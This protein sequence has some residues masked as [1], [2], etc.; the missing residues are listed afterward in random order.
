MAHF[1][2]WPT[3]NG[4]FTEALVFMV[5]TSQLTGQWVA[6]FAAHHC[7]YWSDNVFQDPGEPLPEPVI[8]QGDLATEFPPTEPNTPASSP[9]TPLPAVRVF[10]MVSTN[11]FSFGSTIASDDLETP[12][13]GMSAQV[14]VCLGKRKWGPVDFDPFLI[15]TAQKQKPK[16]LSTFD[17]LLQLNN[18]M[19]PG[20]TAKQLK[21]LLIKCSGSELQSAKV[22]VEEMAERTSTCLL[23][24]YHK[25]PMVRH[26]IQ[27]MVQI[28]HID[29]HKPSDLEPAY[30]IDVVQQ[31]ADHLVAIPGDDEMSKGYHLNHEAFEWV[32]GEVEAKFNQSLV[33]PGQMCVK[34]II[35][36]CVLGGG[37]KEDVG[38]GSVKEDI[39]LCQLENTMLNSVTLCGVPGIHRVLQ[40]HNKVYVNEEGSIKSK[41]QWMLKTE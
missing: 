11:T 19:Q 35:W 25:H 22:S 17:F 7:K 8:S 21:E 6:A 2:N 9:I 32:L 30:I 18:F 13:A 31:L 40:E 34:M 3:I 20:L 24:A 41:K 16:K 28:F 38:M 12:T 33:N 5:T 36:C 29:W 1:G 4:Q 26:I 15:P 39:F 14:A 10:C 37:D 27:N 23:E